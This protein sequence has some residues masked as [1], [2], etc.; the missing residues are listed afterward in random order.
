MNR[1]QKILSGII[2]TIVVVIVLIVTYPVPRTETNEPSEF[3]DFYTK[4]EDYFVTRIGSVPSIDR[5]TYRL[6]VKGLIDNPT[7]FSLNELQA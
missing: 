3:P 2:L 6:E 5:E 1:N 4:N 7:S